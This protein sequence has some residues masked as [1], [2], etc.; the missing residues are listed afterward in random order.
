[1]RALEIIK[2]SDKLYSQI[3]EGKKAIR[4]FNIVKIGLN[5]KREDLYQKINFRVDQMMKN[6]LLEEV[7]KL[8][9]FENYNALKTVGYTELFDYLNGKSTLDYAIDKIK[10]H[11]RN[12]A[13]R[14]LT[15][16]NADKEIQWFDSNLN[17]NLISTL[18]PN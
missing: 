12:Y 8:K 17:E 11:T 9:E 10:Q 15:W 16:F 7:K 14:Q 4:D 1:M 3:I 18:N 6:G 2:V 13:K 5:S